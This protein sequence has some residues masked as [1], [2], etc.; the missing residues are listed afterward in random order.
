MSLF[1]SDEKGSPDKFKVIY[2][3][4]IPPDLKAGDYSTRITY[5]ITAI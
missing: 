3:L 5:S 2:E 4:S 1:I